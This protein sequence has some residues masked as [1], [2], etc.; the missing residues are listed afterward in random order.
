LGP[1]LLKV[2][3]SRTWA[4]LLR[5]DTILDDRVSLKRN[6]ARGL[7]QSGAICLKYLTPRDRALHM[8]SYFHTIVPKT[9]TLPLN[10]YQDCP[11]SLKHLEGFQAFSKFLPGIF[12]ILTIVCLSSRL[13]RPRRGKQ[14]TRRCCEH[15]DLYFH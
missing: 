1:G 2:H 9:A 11:C 13:S 14:Y 10:P 7:G 6:A 12:S 3:P 15:L 5:A 4:A 8:A